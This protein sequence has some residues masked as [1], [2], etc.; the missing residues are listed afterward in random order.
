MFRIKLLKKQPIVLD[1]SFINKHTFYSKTFYLHR[2]FFAL[3]DYR[4]FK[5]YVL[6]LI[7][8]RED[9]QNYD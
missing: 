5:M 8:K 3:I 4:C 2:M 7:A 1:K 6:T 9:Q